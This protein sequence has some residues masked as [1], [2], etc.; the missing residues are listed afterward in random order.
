MP[1]PDLVRAQH[2]L[3]AGREVIE[4]TKD[5]TRDDLV[6]DRM[7][8]YSIVRLFEIIGEA[9]NNITQD[10]QT[11]HPSIPWIDII[12]MR[13]RLIHGYNDINLDIIWN[14]VKVDVPVFVVELESIL[15]TE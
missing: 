5:K 6:S 2:M 9:A 11:K 4:F 1:Q 7:L 14:T 12:A 8:Y 10:F 3:D 15:G 13:H